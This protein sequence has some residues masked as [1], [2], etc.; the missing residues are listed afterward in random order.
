LHPPHDRPVRSLNDNQ[1]CLIHNRHNG[2]KMT[3]VAIRKDALRCRLHRRLRC[4]D[5]FPLSRRSSTTSKSPTTVSK[6]PPPTKTND[7]LAPWPSTT[8]TARL[9]KICRFPQ[10]LA[11]TCAVPLR[12]GA[13]NDSTQRGGLDLEAWF[14]TRWE[15]AGKKASRRDARRAKAAAVAPRPVDKLRPVVR[16]PYVQTSI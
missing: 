13:F 10:G 9:I 4:A 6:S 8:R 1:E 11:E 7:E 2:K 15:Q 3:S 12:P 16:C 5:H 14:L